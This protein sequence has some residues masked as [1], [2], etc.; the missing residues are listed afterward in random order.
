MSVIILLS[1]Y[2]VF[3]IL[4]KSAVVTN[5]SYYDKSGEAY[6]NEDQIIPK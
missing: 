2:S 3:L 5:S 4:R 1:I 6:P